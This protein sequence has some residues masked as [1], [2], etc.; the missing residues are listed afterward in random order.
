MKPSKLL[1]GAALVAG[2]VTAL[3]VAL[4]PAPAH[5]LPPTKVVTGE[6][7]NNSVSPKSVT[8]QCPPEAPFLFGPGGG[9]DGGIVGGNGSV[10]LQ[11]V[12]PL[13]NPPTRFRVT[14]AEVGN[15]TGSWKVQAFGI[16]GLFTAGL[17]VITDTVAQSTLTPKEADARCPTGLALYGTGFRITGGNGTAL[18]HDVIPGTTIAPRGVTVRGSARPGL[19]PSWRLDGFAICA[20]PAF[21]MRIEQSLTNPSTTSPKS[22]TDTCPAGTFAHGMGAQTSAEAAPST[23]VDGRIALTTMAPL[24]TTLG[25]TIAAAIGTVSD[26][27][28]LHVYVICSS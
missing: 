18:V 19:S 7:A 20:N 22:I 2:L 26:N 23:G 25:G 9:I 27:W 15:F 13:D 1:W 17:Q 3:T 14:A 24:F 21:T 10:A 16:C 5:A 4:P 12:A 11:E 28:R 6:S 8:V